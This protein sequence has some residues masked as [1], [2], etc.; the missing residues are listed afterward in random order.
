MAEYKLQAKYVGQRKGI[1]KGW[2]TIQKSKRMTKI[3]DPSKG[4]SK[5]YKKNWKYKVIV[6]Q[7]PRKKGL[8][9]YITK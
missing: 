6:T 8:M 5:K 1:K 2:F 4:Q 9:D 7:T 3:K